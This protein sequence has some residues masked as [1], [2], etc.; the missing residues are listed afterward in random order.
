VRTVVITGAANGIGRAAV[1]LLHDRGWAVIA[2]DT[3]GCG[4]ET[5]EADQPRVEAVVG[6]VV[7]A[8]T[9]WEARERAEARGTLTGWVNNA[10][11]L[12]LGPLHALD[13][14]G[15]DKTLSVNLRAVLLGAQ[16][17]VQSFLASRTAGSSIH[18][19]AAFPDYAV[20]DTCKGGVEALTRYVCVEYGHLGIRCNAVAP[21]A[22]MTNIVRGLLDD[23]ADPTQ[24]LVELEALSP[25][26]TMIAPEDIAE[27]VAFLL[28]DAARFV[29][30]HVLA[31]DGGMAARSYAF[32]ADPGLGGPDL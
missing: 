6:D 7:E 18:A 21:G 28:S 27:A 30:G 23:A 12:G 26:K 9:L 32:P 17:A 10:A 20:Y 29:N 3:D 16:Q 15:I 2:V 11:I 1:Q 13:S 31:V 22:V 8:D 5:L 14:A 24:L 25:M 4:L 19:R